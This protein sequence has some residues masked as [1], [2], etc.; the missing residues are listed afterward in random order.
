MSEVELNALQ[1]ESCG[2]SL[3]G[4]APDGACP[5]CATPIADSLVV[6]RIGSVWQRGAGGVLRTAIEAAWRPRRMMRRLR[7]DGP[8]DWLLI[9]ESILIATAVPALL[10]GMSANWPI[11]GM[12]AGGGWGSGLLTEVQWLARAVEAWLLLAGLLGL[13]V[14]GSVVTHRL[15]GLLRS[16]GRDDRARAICAHASLG[17][18]CGAAVGWGAIGVIA[19]LSRVLGVMSWGD[20][21]DRA[22]GAALSGLAA[23]ACWFVLL[24]GMGIAVNARAARGGR[25]R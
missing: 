6:E 21:L 25:A 23:G 1:C 17:L 4:L 22:T 3:D 19:V 13:V 12:R 7:P 5:E 15:R 24:V 10:M 11:P 8:R 9:T 20:A 16:S 2:Y 14:Y 18:V